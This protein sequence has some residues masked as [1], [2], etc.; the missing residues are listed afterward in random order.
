MMQYHAWI[1]RK[2]GRFIVTE[3]LAY[4]GMSVIY[5]AID[6][7]S[8]AGVALKVLQDGHTHNPTI[9]A[10]FA[11][12]ADIV[13]MLHHDNL[14]DVLDA[15]TID[16][17]IYIAFALID[18]DSLIN[19]IEQRKKLHIGQVIRILTEIGGV[20]DY[21]HSQKIIHRDL[22]LGNILVDSAN[23]AYLIDFGISRWL[24]AEPLTEV[25]LNMPGTARY[26]SPEQVLGGISFNYRADLYS[27][28]VIAYLLLTGYFPF[29]GINDLVLMN[30]HLT[31][32]AA[33]PSSVNPALPDDV[34]A[35]LG[36]MLS[37]KA[38]NRYPDAKSFV[39]A[40]TEALTGA[41][42]L[43]I[44]MHLA[45]ENP[46]QLLPEYRL[47]NVNI[48]QEKTPVST[49]HKNGHEQASRHMAEGH[50]TTTDTGKF[51]KIS[52]TMNR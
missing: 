20:L 44:E 18:G 36:R 38:S 51:R 50:I 6:S 43:V 32:R 14:V 19:L 3:R 10:R 28:G 48:T 25:D 22:K 33:Q 30:Q 26:M 21:I 4:G 27:L 41:G 40:L 15:G 9:A 12:E 7:I 34:N 13:R 24:A 8:G 23:K 16:G 52:A 46:G 45:S 39:A 47:M 2:I 1:G 31:M 37:K 35:I 49:E 5:R 17:R 11:Q 42:N 29:T